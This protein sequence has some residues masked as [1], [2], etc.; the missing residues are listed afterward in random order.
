[1]VRK[2]VPRALEKHNGCF[3]WSLTHKEFVMCA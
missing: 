1:V 2:V 3:I